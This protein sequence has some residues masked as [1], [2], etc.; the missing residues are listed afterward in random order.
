MKKLLSL[1]LA[2]VLLASGPVRADDPGRNGGPIETSADALLIGIPLAALGLTWILQ[3]GDDDAPADANGFR[4]PKTFSLNGSPRHDLALAMGRSL[5]V[6]YGLKYAVQEERPN[7]K[8][9]GSFPSAHAAVTFTGAEFIRKEYGWWWGAPAYLA[10]GYVGWSRTE[11][12]HHYGHDVLAGAAIGILSNHDL[13]WGWL[14][15]R[16]VFVPTG[17]HSLYRDS[18]APVSHDMFDGGAPGVGFEFRF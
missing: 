12:G 13:N 11:T 18:F 3:A 2:A 14:K 16:P 9:N 6:S 10:A 1:C 8:D 15:I 17:D 5:A 4:V 7:G